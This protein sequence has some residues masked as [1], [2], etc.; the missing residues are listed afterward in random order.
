LRGTKIPERSLRSEL[1]AMVQA[2][3]LRPLGEAGGRRYELTPGAET[4]AGRGQF[5]SSV[6]ADRR[7]VLDTKKC[8]GVLKSQLPN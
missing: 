6:A 5:V 2:G 1:A 3:L 8:I 7:Q 4:R